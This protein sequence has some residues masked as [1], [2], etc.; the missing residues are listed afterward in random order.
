MSNTN[1]NNMQTQ[2]LSALHNAIME[3]GGKDRPPMLAFGNS[4]SMETKD[5]LSSCSIS[6]D[7]EIQRLQKKARLSKRGCMKGLKA[8]K[9]NFKILSDDLRDFG[10]VPTF[11]RTFS[12][13]Q[14]SKVDLGKALDVGLVVMENSGTESEVQDTSSRSGN[15]TDTDDADIRPIY[16]EEPMVEI[17]TGHRFSPNKTST[18][19]EKTSPRSDLRW[20][21]TGRNLKIVGLRWVPTGKIFASCIS[22]S[23]NVQKEQSFNLSAGTSYNVN[24]ES[25]RVWLLKKLISQKPVLKWIRYNINKENLRVWLLKKLIS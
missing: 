8:L 17:F 18:V 3:G 12:Q 14:E 20:K 6:K 5:T 15:D 25:L 19:Y 7:Q 23:I 13:T 11:K 2:T 1:N 9:L 21:P 24:K 4:D 16:D 10:G 22:T